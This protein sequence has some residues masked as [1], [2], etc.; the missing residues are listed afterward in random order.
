VA[1]I[2]GNIDLVSTG[3]SQQTTIENI[4]KNAQVLAYRPL[5]LTKE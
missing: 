3:Q 4:S 1:I 5:T 2:K